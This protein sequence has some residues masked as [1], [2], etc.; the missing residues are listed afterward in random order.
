MQMTKPAGCV[1]IYAQRPILITFITICINVLEIVSHRFQHCKEEI[2]FTSALLHRYKLDY[3]LSEAFKT[4]SY[5]GSDLLTLMM[6][7]KL[8]SLKSRDL[9]CNLYLW[10]RKS[11]GN[12]QVWRFVIGLETHVLRLTYLLVSGDL[13]FVCLFLFKIV[14]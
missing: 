6:S 11:T 13:Q 4:R 14:L 8:F 10:T 1:V 5:L 12:L 7:C 3:P 2:Q 9:T